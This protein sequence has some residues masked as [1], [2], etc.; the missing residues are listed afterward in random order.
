MRRGFTLVELVVVLCV[1]ALLTHLAVRE[2]SQVRDRKLEKAADA[3]LETIRDAALAFLADMGRPVAVTNGTLAE[4]WA[5]PSRVPEYRVVPAVEENLVNGAPREL[6]NT[7]VQVA[8][9]WRGPYLRLPIGRD[10][11]LDPWG[12]PIE[13]EDAAGL[14]RIDLTNGISAVSVSHYGATAQEPD[15]RTLSLLPDRGSTSS[16]T[17][18][19]TG[20][21]SGGTV[22][23]GWY[24]P[25]SGLI[26]GAVAKAAMN[27]PCRF[28]GLTP[29]ERVVV[30]EL[31]GGTRRTLRL[32]RIAPG[33]NLLEIRLD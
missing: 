32:V 23:F 28:E 9:G 21:A 10:R 6:V 31:E 3:Q 30:A 11:L 12:N 24:G 27:V 20:E 8:T 22:K 13:L 29:G 7:N 14:P 15:R 33:D 1:L 25:A 2:F 5:R 26:T 18:W 16:L 4:L 17:V 19:A